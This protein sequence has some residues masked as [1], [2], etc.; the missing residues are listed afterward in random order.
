ME[1]ILWVSFSIKP[2]DSHGAEG[3]RLSLM[4]TQATFFQWV[5]FKNSSAK[6]LYLVYVV[7]LAIFYTIKMD[8]DGIIKW[9]GSMCLSHLK[10]HHT[11]T[12]V[13]G[14]NMGDPLP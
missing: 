9:R 1:K 8:I 7:P 5:P 11:E 10:A 14:T 13:G 2:Q 6:T 4:K 3:T 12:R